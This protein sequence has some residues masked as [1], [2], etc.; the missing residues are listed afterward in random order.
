MVKKPLQQE[1]DELGQM[2]SYLGLALPDEPQQKISA[3][4]KQLEQL[5]S[6]FDQAKGEAQVLA[7]QREQLLEQ[8]KAK[9][10]NLNSREAPC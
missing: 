8:H 10:G 1:M 5:K 6:A 4:S 7:Q 2:N 3:V 9:G